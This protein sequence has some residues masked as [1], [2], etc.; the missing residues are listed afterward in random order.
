MSYF[1]PAYPK[2]RFEWTDKVDEVSN[3]MAADVNSLAAEIISLEYILGE[4]IHWEEDAFLL[5]SEIIFYDTLDARISDAMACNRHP[6]C[7]LSLVPFGC[8]NGDVF[9]FNRPPRFNSFVPIFDEFGF[10][11]GSD[12]TIGLGGL[13][14][15]DGWQFWPFNDNGY[16]AHHLYIDGVWQHHDRFD[17]NFPN[18]GPAQW[19]RTGLATRP[20]MTFF[21]WTGNLNPGQRVQC[22]SEN[23]TSV[24]LQQIN[25]GGLR[26]YALR[27]PPGTS[28]G[29]PGT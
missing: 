19:D 23:G 28:Y 2:G 11:N 27:E 21:S 26:C 13:Y 16:V 9:N 17:W 3:V 10:F 22:Y 18:D 20:G 1:R 7:E 15:I 29:T 5:A 14:R 4:M 8:P 25:Q 12:C 24:N 6:Y